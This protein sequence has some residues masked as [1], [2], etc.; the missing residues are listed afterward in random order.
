MDVSYSQ[1]LLEFVHERLMMAGVLISS[2]FGAFVVVRFVSS[3]P[4]SMVQRDGKS[5]EVLLALKNKKILE[6][7]T[8]FRVCGVSWPSSGGVFDDSISHRSFMEN[9]RRR[10]WRHTQT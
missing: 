4:L 8:R 6:E 10:S 1:D 9:L 3:A 5:L 2:R 7:L